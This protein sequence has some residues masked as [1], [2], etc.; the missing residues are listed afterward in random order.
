M[1][2]VLAAYSHPGQGADLQRCHTAVLLNPV[3]TAETE[4]EASEV[5]ARPP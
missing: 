1:V 4:R 2:E 3:R 5:A